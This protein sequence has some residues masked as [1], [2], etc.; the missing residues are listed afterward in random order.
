LIRWSCTLKRLKSLQ[1]QEKKYRDTRKEEKEE[2]EM[3][4]EME[5]EMEQEE[6][7]MGM[8]SLPLLLIFSKVCISDLD[9]HVASKI[10]IDSVFFMFT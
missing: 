8:S 3:E 4:M 5:Q 6:S 1:H 7:L 2:Q 10:K 9:I